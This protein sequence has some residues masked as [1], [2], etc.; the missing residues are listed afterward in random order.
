M[1]KERALKEFSCLGKVSWEFASGFKSS[2][3]KVFSLGDRFLEVRVPT[4]TSD[5]GRILFFE[6]YHLLFKL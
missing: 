5:N 4:V 1:L 2:F 3:S 6:R